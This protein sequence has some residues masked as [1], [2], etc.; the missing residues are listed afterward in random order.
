MA[1]FFHHL[2]FFFHQISFVF[3][4]DFAFGEICIWKDCEMF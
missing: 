3:L 4:Q 2:T 1:F